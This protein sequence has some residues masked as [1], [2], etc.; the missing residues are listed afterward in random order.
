MSPGSTKSSMTAIASSS[1]KRALRSGRKAVTRRIGP[2][3]VPAIVTAVRALPA[4]S[5]I[6]D[7][8]CVVCDEKGVTDFN[9]L[10]SRLTRGS[11]EVFLYA[12]DLLELNGDDLRKRPWEE[13]RPL[14][15]TVLK[16][17]KSGLQLSEHTEGDGEA[18]FPA[19][20]RNGARRLGRK[21]AAIGLSL[22]VRARTG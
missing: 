3:R 15:E 20:L 11:S 14:L 19:C 8:E 5:A 22:G 4:H 9:A 10:R 21:A 1:A 17:A 18:P 16:G 2:R 13:R 7:G 6:I 12:F